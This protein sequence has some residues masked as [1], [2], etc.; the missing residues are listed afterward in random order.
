MKA[1]VFC[2][3]D[4]DKLVDVADEAAFSAFCDGFDA[5]AEA[6][7]G[8]KWH[9]YLLPRDHADMVEK[10][11]VG[12]VMR[13]LEAVAEAEATAVNA[14]VEDPRVVGYP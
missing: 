8:G 11:H 10:E 2:E 4:F 12:E 9:L 7:G 3:D 13:A 1:A 14:G 5:G 6:Y